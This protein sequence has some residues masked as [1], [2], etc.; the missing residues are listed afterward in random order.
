MA[1]QGGFVEILDNH[2]RV[3]PDR[4]ELGQEIDVAK[5]EKE[6]RDAEAAVINPA[7]GIDIASALIAVNHAR[8][9]IDAAGKQ[10]NGEE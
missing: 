1:I 5:A 6:L 2:V 8:A 7:V 3:L 9:R 10:K 4:A